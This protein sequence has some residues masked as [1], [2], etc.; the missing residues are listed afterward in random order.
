MREV[1]LRPNR[2]AILFGC[3]PL[4]VT[5]VLGLWLALGL[6]HVATFWRWLGGLVVALGLFG[7]FAIVR[8][9]WRPRIGYRDGRVLFYLVRGEPIATPVEVVEAFFVGQGPV[10]L[11]AGMG[12]QQRTYNLVA[13][14]SQ[15][16]TDWAGRD[17]KPALGQWSGGYVT[18]RGTWCE[19]LD[20]ELI[21]RL[22]RRLRE[23][24]EELRIE[25]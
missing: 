25:V 13:R 12:G 18:I 5:I 17:V 10:A 8:Q 16:A 14:L 23:V 6:P 11:P 9:L 7:G 1:W 20:D 22:N 24:K 2:R 19:P 15:R 21:R 4:A 3:V